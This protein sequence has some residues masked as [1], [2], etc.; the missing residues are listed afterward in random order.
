MESPT[1]GV[2]ETK[3]SVD[4][5]RLGARVTP[6]TCRTLVDARDNGLC[7]RCWLPVGSRH[8]R[9]PRGMGGRN[10]ADA[11]RPSN[12]VTLCG[13]GT[14]GCH[15]WVEQHRAEGYAAGWLLHDWDDPQHTAALDLQGRHHYW[16]D[17][18]GHRV[19]RG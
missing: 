4:G 2:R 10:R 6:A 18:G 9:K 12:V 16:D 1:A 8:H 11:N 3:R 7:Q 14:T 13:S 19:D 15:G 17:E 5:G